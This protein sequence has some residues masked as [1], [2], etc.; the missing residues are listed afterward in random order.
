MKNIKEELTSK[1]ELNNKLAENLEAAM[2]DKTF[3]A[4]ISKL[5]LTKEVAMKYT[6]KL[7]ETTKE[8]KNCSTCKGLYECKNAYL[9]HVNSPKIV[10][11]KIYFTYLPCKYQKKLNEKETLEKRVANATMKDIETNDKKQLKIIKWMDTFY[12]KFDLS[13][14]LKGLYLHGNFGSGKTFLLTALLNEL[15]NNKNVSTCII[16]FPEALQDLKDDWET[17]GDKMTYYKN[18]DILLIDDIGAEKVTEWGRDEVLGTIL[19]Y[20]MTNN[21][22]TFFTSNLTIEELEKSLSITT[23]GIDNVKSRRIIERIKQL[24][25]DLELISENRRG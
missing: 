4:L 11:N 12:E 24:T 17:F 10:S 20:R 23:N 1:E 5:K 9:G 2:Q 6:T 16:Y 18:V 14:N 19:Q 22:I 3:N 13:K 8:L 21:K 7:E 15:K 25:T